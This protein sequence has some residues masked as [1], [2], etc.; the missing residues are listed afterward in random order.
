MVRILRFLIL[1]VVASLIGT[2]LVK[3]GFINRETDHFVR[4]DLAAL[5]HLVSAE[6]QCSRSLFYLNKNQCIRD[7][8][9][10]YVRQQFL[11]HRVGLIE[12]MAP[13]RNSISVSI[14]NTR[15]EDI[16]LVVNK[17]I[18]E[19]NR[20]ILISNRQ[21]RTDNCFGIFLGTLYRNG[22]ETICLESDLQHI[23]VDFEVMSKDALY[24]RVT[25]LLLTL[26]LVA[27]LVVVLIRG[28]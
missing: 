20:Q 13:R 23:D 27:L 19:A 5:N 21:W 16:E 4:V 6:F 22:L 15:L 8:S 3:D 9:L 25:Q 18:Q 24:F 14:K 2:Y 28:K 26:G 1:F 11:D 7:Q 17:I 12:V 10:V